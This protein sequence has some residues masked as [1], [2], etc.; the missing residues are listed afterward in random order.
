MKSNKML[1]FIPTYNENENVEKIYSKITELN[2]DIDILFLD[3]NSPDGTGIFLDRLAEAH[4]NV[5]VIHRAKKSGVGSA[6]L[7]G[8]R[9]AYDH[10]YEKLITMDCDFTHSPDNLPVFIDYAKN[11]EI[12]IGSR[13]MLKKSLNGWNPIRQF[14]TLSGHVFTKYLLKM[15]YDAS[16]ALRLYRLDKI[17]REVFSFIKSS[18]YSF[19]PESLHILYMKKYD[20]KEIPIILPP[21]SAG[22]SKMK[23]CDIFVGIYKIII[24]FVKSLIFKNPYVIKKRKKMRK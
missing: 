15:P 3:D 7:T 19:F 6:H 21:R 10:K 23:L 20:I 18:G 11:H 12:V 4:Q 9:W 8:I 13:F 22:H 24:L 14:L 5:N 2:L 16:G 17:P 1:I